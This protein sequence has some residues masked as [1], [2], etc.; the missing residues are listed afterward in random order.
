MVVNN[1]Q[2][3]QV[4]WYWFVPWVL[5]RH[6]MRSVPNCSMNCLWAT[7][8]RPRVKLAGNKLTVSS[9]CSVPCGLYSSTGVCGP[10]AFNASTQICTDVWS[11]ASLCIHSMLNVFWV[12]FHNFSECRN[13]FQL[14]SEH[15]TDGS[16]KFV[17]HELVDVLGIGTSTDDLVGMLHLQLSQ[18]VSF[19][20]K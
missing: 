5:P 15:W 6:T 1:Y 14:L 17:F 2:C 13:H 16:W 19:D 12:H 4:K 11:S 20:R 3:Y 10:K 8:S 9:F 7:V 18:T